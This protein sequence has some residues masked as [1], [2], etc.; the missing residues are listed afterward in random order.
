MCL[1]VPAS[2][3][4]QQLPARQALLPPRS[5]HLRCYPLFSCLGFKVWRPVTSSLIHPLG[6]SPDFTP[7]PTP[8]KKSSS[9]TPLETITHP[10]EDPHC[11]I[12]SDILSL[13][14]ISI[15]PKSSMLVFYRCQWD[16]GPM[17]ISTY[18]YLCLCTGPCL[19]NQWGRKIRGPGVN[20]A[21]FLN[22]PLPCTPPSHL[23]WPGHCR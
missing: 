8:R 14:S 17:A 6:K 7:T 23:A 12:W 22:S 20:Q 18:M 9:L 11:L 10:S 2:S 5:G 21:F 13:R 3:G 4:L 19:S 1:C 15:S 16:L